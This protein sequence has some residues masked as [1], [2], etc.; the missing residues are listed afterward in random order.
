MGIEELYA[1]TEYGVVESGGNCGEGSVVF[2]VALDASHPIFAG[3]FPGMPVLPGVCTMHMVK[4]C[5]SRLAGHKLRY[6]AVAEVKFPAAIIPSENPALEVRV[7]LGEPDS[8]GCRSLRAEV[9]AKE[10]I[11]FK[12]KSTVV[13]AV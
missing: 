2:E 3:H 6:V 7:E 10:G 9:I 11:S 8:A 1:L 4:S 12:I 5:A 13:A